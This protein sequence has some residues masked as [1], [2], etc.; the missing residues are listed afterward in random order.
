[1][2]SSPHAHLEKTGDACILTMTQELPAAP[3][4]VWRAITE[5]AQLR[6]W[7]PYDASAS[8]GI[9]S[10][11]VTLTTVGAP[12]PHVVQTAVVRADAPEHLEFD[13]GG[14]QLHWQLQP[15]GAGTRLTL[16]T[17]IPVS[18]AAMGAAGW[19]VCLEALEHLLAGQPSGRKVGMQLMQD[20]AWQRLR[21]D[22][23]RQFGV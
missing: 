10:A 8:L 5:P 3:D 12:A 9:A 17:R 11:V 4:P 21:A 16:R 15:L 1:M 2:T 19:H 14:N 6:E 20:P 13:W 7:A 18:F 23:A 22:Y